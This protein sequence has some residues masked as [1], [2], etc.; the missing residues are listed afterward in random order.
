MASRRWAAAA[1]AATWGEGDRI[2]FYLDSQGQLVGMS[3]WGRPER[4]AKEF[5]LARLLVERHVRADPQ[6]L[7]DPAVKLKSLSAPSPVAA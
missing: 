3:A 7:A 6:A 5:K 4:S 2:V 1:P